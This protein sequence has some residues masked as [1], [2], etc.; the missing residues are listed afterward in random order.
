MCD[1]LGFMTQTD[2]PLFGLMRRSQFCEGVRQ[3]EEM[4]RLVRAHPSNIAVTYI[5]EPFPNHKKEHRQLTSEELESFFRACDEAVRLANPDRVIKAV[6]GDYDPP[7]E[8]LP[9]NH[10]YNYWYN[11][12]GLSVG[13][14][15]KGYWQRVKPGW[16]YGCGEFGT[17]GLDPVETMYKYYPKSWLPENRSDAWDPSKIVQAQ[18][19]R[20]HYIWF[21]TQNTIDDWVHASQKHQALGARMMTEA[22]RRDPRMVSCAIHLFIDAFPSGWMKAIMDVD[23]NPKP[24]YFAYREALAPLAANIRMDRRTYFAGE[25]LDVEFWVCNDRDEQIKGCE[26]RYQLRQ[27]NRIVF[28]G[29]RAAVIP[30]IMPQYQGTLACALPDVT[31]RTKITVELAVVGK[32][33]RGIH[34]T[35]KDIEVFPRVTLATR[36]VFILG[37]KDGG[38]WTLA[39]DLGLKSRAWKKGAGGIILADSIDLVRKNQK[40]LETAVRAGARLILTDLPGCE[41]KL[42]L[43]GDTIEFAPAGMGS[44][45]FVNCQ[46]NHPW[47]ED[48]QPEDFF[49]WHDSRTGIFEPILP[50]TMQSSWATV[51]ATGNGDWRAAQ[52]VPHQ[53]AAVKTYEKGTIIVSLVILAGK[54]RTNPT[55][56]EYARRILES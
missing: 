54:T 26:I 27:G 24:A 6:D 45:F 31:E 43:A 13:K 1:R 41:E 5:N 16:N 18:T 32:N 15:N 9:D 29:R 21:T 30:A 52:W 50:A 44:R 47:A 46:T 23:R 25:K 55:A 38:A 33:G 40:D 17:E 12:H 19:A 48:F 35:A 4:E 28:S 36:E 11:G 56:R 39:K 53:A 37:A 8:G 14:L 49:L 51:L 7:H 3:A 10:C 20:F 34:D 22:F 2:L 42:E